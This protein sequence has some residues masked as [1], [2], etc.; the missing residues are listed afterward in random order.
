MLSST[1]YLDVKKIHIAHEFVLDRS[2]KC[3]Y[4]HGRGLFGLV[5]AISGNAEYRFY[6]GK[7]ITVC[8]GDILFL[9]PNASYS[10]V[11]DKAFRHYTVNFEIH[12]QTSQLGDLD[13]QFMLLRSKGNDLISLEFKK[14]KDVWSKKNDGFEMQSASHLYSLLADLYYDYARES[15]DQRL[16]PAKEYIE[17]NFSS[18]ISL[19][20]L[21]QLCS[22]S[23]TNFRREWKKRY[24]ISPIEYRDAVRISHAK[25]YLISGYYTVSEVAELCGYEDV[26]Y[27][28]RF[29]KRKNGITPGKLSKQF[30]GIV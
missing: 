25:E 29:F 7:R 23:M 27:F 12:R 24:G 22:M 10:I 17:G 8:Q 14:L 18:Q 28:V 26:S 20:Y 5:Y 15:S 30:L 9:S 3:E 21:S 19:S 2:H 11:T 4:P 6:G 16:L 1:F 13:A